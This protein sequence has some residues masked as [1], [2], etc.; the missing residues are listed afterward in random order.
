MIFIGTPQNVPLYLVKVC[1]VLTLLFQSSDPL[2]AFY[3]SINNFENSQQSSLSLK[4]N[5]SNIR[6]LSGKLSI[7]IRFP[8][9]QHSSLNRRIILLFS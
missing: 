6:Q 9:L 8:S 5:A 7:V 1:L 4:R 2:G 3:S